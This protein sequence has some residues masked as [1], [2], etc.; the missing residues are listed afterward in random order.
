M[1]KVSAIGILLTLFVATPSYGVDGVIEINDA[2]ALAGGITA[3]DTAGY[4]VTISESGSYRLTGNLSQPSSNTTVINIQASNVT[5]DLNGFSILGSTVCSGAPVSSCSPLGTGAGIS[6]PSSVDN[7]VVKN[8]TVS[9]MADNCVSLSGSP[10]EVRNLQVNNCGDNGI[11]ASNI[12][13]IDNVVSQ[14]NRLDGIK[15]NSTVPTVRNCRIFRNGGDGI[16]TSASGSSGII[17]GNFINFNGGDGINA[18]GNYGLIRN[19]VVRS[20]ADFGADIQFT[21]VGFVNNV[22]SNNNSS[23]A[24]TS[25]GTSLGTN[26]CGTNTT[27][28]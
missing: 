12:T 23:G 24:Q 5:L 27:C 16:E 25:G 22:F 28:P 2:A 18:L 7:V 8:G 4:P 17:E 15:L 20:N 13:L 10:N 19:N 3:G 14:D 11:S 1:K 9:G 21:T 6:A 26:L